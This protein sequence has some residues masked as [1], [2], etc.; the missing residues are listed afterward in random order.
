MKK[1]IV[2]TLAALAATG[3]LP[4]TAA[5]ADGPSDEA[6]F[7]ARIN[8]LRATKGLAGLAGDAGLTGKARRWAQRMADQGTIWHSALSDENSSDWQKLG[9][10][11][12]RGG[13]VAALDLAFINS[14]HHYENLV[15][16]AFGSIG[17]G[18]AR[19]ADGTIFVA[20]EFMQL[21][22]PAAVPAGAPVVA[23]VGTKAPVAVNT[24][25]AVKAPAAVVP[26]AVPAPVAVKAALVS[27]KAPAAAKA[28]R[29]VPVGQWIAEL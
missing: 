15:D 27:Q 2:L 13:S 22:P 11:V 20:E 16:P 14:L 5:F 7:V 18:V 26:V 23:P 9:E 3:L 6:S 28:R 8:T 10:N 12:G 4:M 19:S 21:R 24:P 25:A 29:A 1:L 17:L